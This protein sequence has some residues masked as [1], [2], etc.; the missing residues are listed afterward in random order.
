MFTVID[1]FECT[2]ESCGYQW[3]AFHMPD[4]CS[5][6]KSRT[7]NRSEA[8]PA[9]QKPTKAPAKPTGRILNN[10]PIRETVYEPVD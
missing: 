3:K 5:S 10:A 4:R 1:A 6:C 7:W 8:A 2:C 9:S